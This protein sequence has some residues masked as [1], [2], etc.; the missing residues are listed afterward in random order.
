MRAIDERRSMYVGVAS[1]TAG[2]SRAGAK[3]ARYQS[4]S[5]ARCVRSKN[6]SS[7]SGGSQTCGWSR[8]YAAIDDV[9]DFIAPTI[10]KFG[11]RPAATAGTLRRRAALGLLLLEVVDPL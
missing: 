7:F 8:R 6:A 5:S 4:T 3:Q 2:S 9:P 11:S 1:P 10:R